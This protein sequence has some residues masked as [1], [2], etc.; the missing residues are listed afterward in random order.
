M[1][2]KVKM[3]PHLSEIGDNVSGIHTVIRKY[4][5][6]LPAFG[7]ELVPPDAATFDLRAA[8]A[9]ITG[10]DCEVC[11]CHG[12]YWTADYP[13]DDWE[14]HVNS[15]VVEACR[16]AR[17]ITVPSD[18]VAETFQ[19]DMR[20]NPHVIPHGVDWAEWQHKELNGGYVL[21][22]KNR[23][24]ADVC[25]NSILDVLISRF[26]DV[27]FVST[28]ITPSLNG[29][30]YSSG[31]WPTNFKI[32]ETGG[33]TP[34]EEMRLYIQRAG[35]YLSTTKET[36]GLA[37][38]EALASGTPVLGWDFGGNSFLVKHGVSGYLA[39]PGDVDDLCEGLSYCLKYRKVLS[40]NARELARA[41]TWE[42]AASVV[43]DIYRLALVEQPAA[44][45]VVIPVYNKPIEQ[46]RRA[47]SSCLKQTYLPSKIIVVNDGSS[48]SDELKQ[49][50]DYIDK[51]MDGMSR[52]FYIEQSNQG[53]AAARNNGIAHT[54]S[55][56]I[57]CLDADDWFEPTF[58][59][60][61]VKALESD[62]SLGIAY[63]GLRAHNTD[64]SS[65]ISEWPG[66]FNPD[67]QLS[68]PKQNQIPTA[69]VFRRDAWERVGGYKSRYAP[70]GCGSE[71]AALWSAI[72]SIG[73][74]A[75]KVTEEALFNYSA[76]GGFVHGNREYI[77]VDWLSMYPWAKDGFHPFASVAT[78]KKW[79]HPV[80]QYDEPAISVI[81]P[82]GPGHEKEVA[83][84]LDSLEM[85]MFRKW[86]AIV[87]DD[88]I[89]PKDDK[90]YWLDTLDK[91]YP[92][93]RVA[94][95]AGQ[96]GAGY[97]RNLGVSIARAPLLFF[98]DADDVLASPDALQIMLD[99]WNQQE[100]I[101]YSDYYGK[102]VWDYQE[103][104][105]EFRER[106]YY[107][108]QKSQTAVFRNNAAEYDVNQA[109]R[110]PEFNPNNPT[111]P[112]FHW[113]LV[114]VLIPKAWHNAIGG[115]DES[116]KTWEDVD[117]HWRLARAG[118][119]FHHL[120][121]PLVIYFYHK[122][123]RRE[124]SAVNNEESLQQH[125]AMIQYIKQK[126]EYQVEPVGCNCGK[127]KQPAING[128]VQA[129]GVSDNDFVMIEF[130]FPGSA[131]RDSYGKALISPTGQ[132]GPDGR[133]LDYRGYGRSKGD[134]F[135]VHRKDQIARPDM[136][137][138]VPNEVKLPET[139]KVELVE[140]VLIAGPPKR[141]RRV[142]VTA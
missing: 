123:H 75:K 104:V 4:F 44:V 141:G 19:R 108:H 16:S 38:L 15:R 52:I 62:R 127:R 138:L 24:G 100:A 69:C 67:K 125:K 22:A 56:Y 47:I 55:K 37:T 43:T 28:F 35:V 39:K 86:E 63:T 134:R 105:H 32:I 60:I 124:L 33:K 70:D 49:V 36:F 130:D 90:D 88:T 103:A 53:V 58:L 50:F 93:V 68:Y 3:T 129:S 131:T 116:M 110:Q 45:S 30:P 31:M 12:V 112:Y 119:C 51:D 95:T 23:S 139:P 120:S 92:Y 5:Q 7:I 122:G 46:V 18:W 128:G 101:I 25:D 72:C 99:A 21:W 102:A 132:T 10:P 17:I 64:G 89:P 137:R 79:S 27:P 96:K 66:K 80:R 81:I 115:F 97:S 107:Y 26:P 142:K 94:M 140:P 77:E 54:S 111:M 85:Q 59:E 121:E 40:A 13:A 73:Y 11:H 1:T 109:Q 82:V 2:I 42:K 65:V 61:C 8:H 83:N 133:K 78:P 113:C 9:G 14:W 117:Y 106:L 84:A 34:H 6:H 41:W 74:N 98:L 114:S 91:S 20:L 136:F 135:L 76:Q 87:V 118:Y 71:D 48:N 29:I 57:I 126:P